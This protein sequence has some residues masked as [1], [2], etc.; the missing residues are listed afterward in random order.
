M[1]QP[2]YRLLGLVLVA[3]C[4][5]VGC[6]SNQESFDPTEQDVINSITSILVDVEKTGQKGSAYAALPDEIERLRSLNTEKANAVQAEYE[7]LE[8]AS[9]PKEIK[10]L[11]A[12]AK[13]KL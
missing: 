9:N 11:A 2:I 1:V 7:K 4:L 8:A 5:L 3:T 6:S 12:E 13:K 10:T